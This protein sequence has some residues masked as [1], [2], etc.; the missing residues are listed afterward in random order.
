[1]DI[2][3]G[4]YKTIW[5]IKEGGFGEVFLAEKEGEIKKKAYILKTFLN[6]DNNDINLKIL[7]NEIKILK[8][9]NP[10]VE[11]PIPFIPAV[12]WPDK[13]ENIN[14]T[15]YYVIDYFSH[16]NLLDYIENSNGFLE[17]TAKMIF[18][19][20]V[21]RI[22]FCHNKNI[23]HLDIKP[24]N[25]VFD[26]EFEPIIID[27]GLSLK[28]ND[29]KIY[30]GETGTEQYEC[31]E[32][33]EKGKFTGVEA[34]IFSLGALL[35]NLIAPSFGFLQAKK[36]DPYYSLII[37]DKEKEYWNKILPLINNI[38][39]SENF[40]NLY[41]KMIAYESKNRPTIEEI[42][43]HP[44]FDEIKNLSKEVEKKEI[45]EKLGEIYNKIKECNPSIKNLEQKIENYDHRGPDYKNV[46][47]NPELRAK[48]IPNDIINPNRHIII[49]GYL[50][51]RKFMNN[52]YYK[53]ND[54]RDDLADDLKIKESDE[55]L[56]LEVIFETE[57]KYH[58]KCII[59]IELFKYG[60]NRYLLD[61]L[62]RS[63]NLS[64][65]YKN[66]RKIK[67]II[68]FGEIKNENKSN[69]DELSI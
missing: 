30:E 39:L 46:F 59:D 36:D 38:E 35:F 6:N 58:K 64:D 21:E 60:E 16:G 37:E 32:M 62:R 28:I 40:K 11:H 24:A 66:F 49:D 41:T 29:D 5:R 23:C 31:P 3:F 63:G 10:N 2:K 27:F 52:L 50:D 42:L 14:T 19:K 20:I 34:D 48:K 1:M 69:N 33:W 45:A 65:Y 67:D 12:Y 51:E 13:D 8:E 15:S 68:Q 47:P 44:W 7:K 55:E 18:K 61:F 9:I 54:K 43:A 26:N 17:R 4:E 25:I 22:Q 56:R 53:I 57:N